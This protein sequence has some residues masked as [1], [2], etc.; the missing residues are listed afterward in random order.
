MQ[1]GI[2][3][4]THGHLASKVFSVFNDVDIIFH[5]GD[6]GDI[7]II[8]QLEI[9]CPVFAVYGNIDKRPIISKYPSVLVKELNSKTIYLT[10]N[11][12]SIKLHRYVLFKKN[13]VPNVVIYGHTHKLGYQIF[14][15]ILYINP[16]SASK[17][18]GRD[19]GSVAV[20]NLDN[21]PLIPKFFYL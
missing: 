7:G 16:G 5:A 8:Q 17:P 13:I 10:H 1:I 2:I 18:K 14:R 15:N 9:L 20:L 21:N 6:I 3:S 12:V 19:V 11:I 4:D